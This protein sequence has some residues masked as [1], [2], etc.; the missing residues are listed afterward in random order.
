M[1]K[2]TTQKGVKL[3]REDGAGPERTESKQAG[4]ALLKSEKRFRLIEE[5][6]EEVFWMADID[7]Q[8]MFYISPK[9][10]HLWGRT[11]QSLYDNPRSFIDAIHPEDRQRVLNDL[12][13]QR[14]GQAFNHE[15]RIVQPDGSIRWIWDR[16][17]PVQQEGTTRVT[18]YAG[19]ASDITERKK[20][21]E[22][23]K[24]SEERFKNLFVNLRTIALVIDPVDGSI[25]D[26]NSAAE[27]YYGW[28]REQLKTMRISDINTQPPAEIDAEIELSR[29]EQRNYFV[30]KHRKADGTI[31][32]VE[33]YSGPV[34]SQG[35]ILLY[36]II[37]DITERKKVQ[38][39]LRESE[40]RLRQAIR[41]SESGIFDH[42]HL[43]NAIY[44]SPQQRK[45]Y[46]WD[47]EETVTLQKFLDCVYPEDRE[48]IAVAVG[49]AHAPAG[50]GLFDVEHRIIRRDGTI[51]W[52]T[53]RSQTFFDGEGSARRKVRTIGAVLDITE[54]KEAEET[55]RGSEKF[56]RNVLNTVDEGFTVIDPDYRILTANNSYC[57]QAFLP[58]DDVIGRHCYEILHKTGQPCYEE[59]EECAVRQV[60]ATGRPH[61]AV[62]KHQDRNGQVLHVE[63]KAFPLKDIA[64][65]VISVIETIN[66]ITEKHLLEEERLKVQ[67]LESIGT[68]AGGIAHDFNNLLQGVFGYISLARMSLDR[69]EQVRVMLE[70]AE[71][72]LHLS[73]NLTTQLLT[74][75]KGGKP[76]RKVIWLQT[77]IENSVKFALSGS[78]T[79]HLLDIA[80]EL[81]PVEADEGQLAQVIQ[82]I[83]L[84]AHEAMEGRGTVRVSARNVNFARETNP[85]LPDGGRFVGVDIQDSGIGIPEQNLAKIFD[86]Y[87]TTKQRGS[88][89]G[90]ATSYSIIKNHGGVIEVKSEVNRGSTFSV[91]LPATEH[92]E[93]AASATPTPE[94]TK[95]GRV[96]V[97][98]D[99]EVV[100]NVAKKMIVALGHEVES[101]SDGE[102]A[103]EVFRHAMEAGNPFDLVILDVT[104]KRGMGGEEAIGKL[105]EIDPEV[106]AVVSSGYESNRVVADH[107]AYGFAAS[108]NKPYMID[109][110]RDCLDKLLKQS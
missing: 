52:V 109:S 70:Q 94:S 86:P 71:E 31:R 97:M 24:E 13:V 64:G 56:I 17:F 83:V 98:D 62:H 85:G 60:F 107:R 110:L 50:V 90:L 88:G 69:P 79:D 105:R 21:E 19:V 80:T 68:L 81:W 87:F 18:C 93:A 96:L 49:W 74:F 106:V 3:P 38:E 40:E 89:L 82:N 66:N 48:R 95:K 53:T 45:I 41:V 26:V 28:T 33:V 102:E 32:N 78:H 5:T 73:V 58:R 36:S 91:Y 11:R 92:T 61:S 42:D 57:D 103:V 14:I 75:S 84:N 34:Q 77:T 46:G 16:G 35:R 25:V 59:G 7:I 27:A 15:Y 8:K 2:R 20:A 43:T 101:A 72:A 39:A 76:V 23:L 65:R 67:K 100:L 63:T 1:K 30:F 54:R 4:D 55:L 37:H 99:Q 29:T 104:V 51:R 108:L 22:A 47:P 44:W 12:K 9:Y 6:I 10:E